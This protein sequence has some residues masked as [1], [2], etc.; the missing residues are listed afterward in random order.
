MFTLI[1]SLFTPLKAF[2]QQ[3]LNMCVRMFPHGVLWN[4]LGLV[5]FVVAMALAL[6]VIVLILRKLH[7]GTYV[8]QVTWPYTFSHILLGAAL[9]IAGLVNPADDDWRTIL[10][11]VFGGWAVLALLLMMRR[12][13]TFEK[14]LLLRLLYLVVGLAYGVELLAVG[15]FSVLI[16]YA[17]VVVVIVVLVAL[18]VVFGGLRS[19]FPQSSGGGGGGTVSQREAT[20]EDGTK[21]VEEGIGW[22]EVGGS[23]TYNENMDGTFSRT[24]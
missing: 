14:S 12:A 3:V 23:K 6:Y 10:Y 17:A 5:T 8:R 21:V 15:M 20:L 9:G 2:C 4:L 18:A 16:V 7:S 1:N 24:S 13:F 22:R 19:M 11:V